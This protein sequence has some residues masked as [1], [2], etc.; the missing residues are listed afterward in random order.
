MLLAWPIDCER[1][2]IIKKRI[3]SLIVYSIIVL[4]VGLVGFTL[5]ALTVGELSPNML[6]EVISGETPQ[7]KIAAYLQAIQAQDRDAA[8]DIWIP[9]S[10]NPELYDRRN[11]VTD[12]LLAHKITGFTIFEP[13]W[14][15][16]CCEPGVVFDARNAGGARVRVQVLDQSGQPWSYNFD[17]F[18][19][20]PYF[21]AAE[22]NPY[23]HWMLR[24]VYPAGDLPL[25]WRLLYTG[26]IQYP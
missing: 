23:R 1:R 17:V 6:L 22:G 3:I 10:S 20:G 25:Y 26:T 12:E 21:G 13:Q 9:P 7:A 16:T 18:V 2:N 15:K 24:D 19:D 5:G 4:V 11:Q 8:L 14:W